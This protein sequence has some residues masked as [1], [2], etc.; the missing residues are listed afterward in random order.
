MEPRAT[1]TPVPIPEEE[2]EVFLLIADE[3]GII[4]LRLVGDGFLGKFIKKVCNREDSPVELKP[5][6]K[7]SQNPG[8]RVYSLKRCY[9]YHIEH[10][11]LAMNLLSSEEYDEIKTVLDELTPSTAIVQFYG[12]F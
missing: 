5:I 11:R 6:H 9:G 8:Y 1:T 3:S 12:S 10:L 4:D 2:Q 7:L